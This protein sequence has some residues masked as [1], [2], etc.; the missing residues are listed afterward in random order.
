MNRLCAG[1][2]LV[3]AILCVPVGAAHQSSDS[4]GL[5]LHAAST[6]GVISGEWMAE[7][8]PDTG[9]AHLMIHRRVGADGSDK[10][11]FRLA[12]YRLEGLAQRLPIQ[13]G[14]SLR[15]QL[16][17]EAGIFLF[18]G[19]FK[20]GNGSGNYTY[21]ADPAFTAEMKKLGYDTISP[22]DQFTM[23][24]HDIGPSLVRSLRPLKG[25]SPSLGELIGVGRKGVSPD[26]LRELK[27]AGV[28]PKSL[29]EVIE[30]RTQGVSEGF[31]KEIEALGYERPTADELTEMRT[32]GVTA[33]FIKELEAMGYKRPPI[34]KLVGMKIQGVSVEFIRN[35]ETMGYKNPSIEQLIGMKIFGVTPEFIKAVVSLGYRDLSI[36][37]L[38]CLRIHGITVD[39]I[40]RTMDREQRKLSLR[41]LVR[42]RN[43]GGMSKG[44]CELE[45]FP[46]KLPD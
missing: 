4:N 38:T 37:Q 13:D 29:D 6:Q 5:P 10:R 26:Y 40:D 19:T 9:T 7:F 23:A 35:V 24:V 39:F 2:G 46:D 43:P 30:M 21:K 27:A 14:S 16:K 17:R 34:N 36:N 18:E 44:S 20:G 25:G 3:L 33:A 28:E 41:E 31:I 12:L 1:I 45:T 22:E 15:F 32:M 42:L 8:R 11:Y